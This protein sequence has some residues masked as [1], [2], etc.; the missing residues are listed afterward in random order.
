[1]IVSQRKISYREDFVGRKVHRRL[2]PKPEFRKDR[3]FQTNRSNGPLASRFLG[4]FIFLGRAEF[5][6]S[7]ELCYGR[8]TKQKSAPR[9]QISAAEQNWWRTVHCQHLREDSSPLLPVRC[10]RSA[11]VV[12]AEHHGVHHRSLYP[13]A[14]LLG[15][16][17]GPPSGR[18]P[19]LAR[20][21]P[22][23]RMPRGARS[24]RSPSRAR[25]VRR[26]GQVHWAGRVPRGG[27]GVGAARARG[28]RRRLVRAVPP[29]RA[30]RR[31]GLRGIG[32]SAAAW[33]MVIRVFYSSVLV[34]CRTLDDDGLRERLQCK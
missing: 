32:Y 11:H 16:P 4:N 13:H 15:S 9:P 6:A 23:G 25:S 17:R 22:V 29:H 14:V 3:C 1:V 24:P 5:R 12:R 20:S 19:P 30:R 28:L 31:L 8:K 10:L 18:A 34:L 33:W 2:I 7:D 27:A 26:G 21:A